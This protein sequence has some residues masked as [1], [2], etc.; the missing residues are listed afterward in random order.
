MNE[1]PD[2]PTVA[3]PTVDEPTVEEPTVSA[4][5]AEPSG[6]GEPGEPGG[7]GAPGEPGGA[8][9]PGEPGGAGEPGAPGGPDGAGAP[10]PAG[11]A[12]AA[13]YGLVRPLLGRYLG[14]VCAAIGRATNTDPVLWRVLLAVTSFFGIGIVVYLLGWLLI[15]AEGDTASPLEALL[16]RGRSRTS[17]VLAVIL[18]LGALLVLGGMLTDGFRGPLLIV[19]VVVGG[20]L[21]LSRNTERARAGAA[22]A[23]YPPPPYAP[24]AYPPPIPAPATP[25]GPA[26]PYHPA[27][28]YA[29]GYRPAAGPY[30]AAYAAPPAPPGAP[31]STGMGGTTTP[32]AP[33]GYRPPF[34]PRGPYASGGPALPPQPPGAYPAPPRPPKP[35]R[36]RSRLGILTFSLVI[37][38][39]GAV[40]ALDMADVVNVGVGGYFAAMLAMVGLGLVVGAWVGRARWLIALGLAFAVALG[41]ATAAER[42]DTRN[43]GSDVVWRPTSAADLAN[44]YELNVGSAD[45]D[46]RQVD[47]TNQDRE[48]AVRVNAGE[49]RVTLPPEVDATVRTDMTAGDAQ[50]FDT[51]W[52]GLNT[53]TRDI[54]D[55]GADAEGGGK[56]RLTIRINAGTVEVHR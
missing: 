13:R 37:L 26:T 30:G 2:E 3:E 51:R 17:P 25:A 34:A 47:F 46:L 36:E 20:V 41:I 10:G 21:L 43:F 54:T 6:P 1:Q 29:A 12:F 50:I 5:A 15:P 32:T 23:G 7:A 56:L 48:V 45:L 35:P 39:L 38:A 19:A 8:G 55:L 44:R 27:S 31:V 28:G 16:G 24:A 14:G 9:A 53:P 49:L 4:S 42:I 11:S 22:A 33:P 52:S 40:A 18:G